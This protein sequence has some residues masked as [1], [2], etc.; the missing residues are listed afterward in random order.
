[1]RTAFVAVFAL[2]LPV[3]SCSI[4]VRPR[5]ADAVDL[6]I[7]PDARPAAVEYAS[8]A[9]VSFTGS[10]AETNV[11][12]RTFESD[13]T[14]ERILDFYRKILRARRGAFVECRG[15]IK[16]RRRRGEETLACLERP[17]SQGVQLAGGVEG[18]HSVV[19][20]TTRGSAAH[21]T[22]LAVH[23]GG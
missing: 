23:T 11:V 20:V 7:Y 21:F 2:V 22:V 17:S 12:P 13:D 1:M 6:P 4:D 14:P 15:A 5:H 16:I 3:T 18:K 9:E 19:R 10:F 8:G